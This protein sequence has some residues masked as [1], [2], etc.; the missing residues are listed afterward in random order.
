MWN[1]ANIKVKNVDL[2]KLATYVEKEIEQE[3]LTWH[4]LQDVVDR[5]EI[6]KDVIK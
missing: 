2:D 6:A 3:K 5:K 1:K 4:D